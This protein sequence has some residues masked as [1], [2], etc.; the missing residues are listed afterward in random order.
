M[1]SKRLRIFAGPNGS[2]KSVLY[3][4]LVSQQ[5]F[6]PYFYINADDIA[7]SL[8]SGFS[9]LNWHIAV[10]NEDFISFLRESTFSEHL[11]YRDVAEYLKIAENSFLWTGEKNGLSYVSAV[12]ADYLRNKMLLSES[13]F[14]CETVFSHPSKL[15]FLRR[16]RDL[17]F[18]IYLYFISTK[19]PIINC[20][21]VEN[22]VLS[23][24]H[25]V[26]AEKIESRYY[27]TMNN[28]LEAVKL[29]DKAFL[30]DN[31]ES[32]ENRAYIN[33]ANYDAAGRQFSYTGDSVPDWF[34]KY[35]LNRI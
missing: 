27:K 25:D 1:K 10:S 16:A 2:G 15:E 6:T 29:S 23:G 13:S 19:N 21:R 22:R 33:F 31:S 17:G 20:G 30:F 12:I 7:Q 14:A 28:L 9:V 34:E 3:R 4:Y 24:G 32:Q 11:N 26:P 5:L 8:A 35:V 18:K